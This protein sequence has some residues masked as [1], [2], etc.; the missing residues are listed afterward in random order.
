MPTI[1]T[2]GISINIIAYIFGYIAKDIILKQTPRETEIADRIKDFVSALIGGVEIHDHQCEEMKCNIKKSLETRWDTIKKNYNL[3]DNCLS[4]LKYKLCIEVYDTSSFL[5]EHRWNVSGD[6]GEKKYI[7]SLSFLVSNVLEHHKNELERHSK[8]RKWLNNSYREGIA[9]NI[10]EELV[11]TVQELIKENPDLT[12]LNE[13][14]DFRDENQRQHEDMTEHINHRFD[15]LEERISVS[16]FPP[17][18]SDGTKDS[19]EENIILS[20]ERIERYYQKIS[21]IV[22]S[23]RVAEFS[24]ICGS[25]KIIDTYIQ[26]KSINENEKRRPLWELISGAINDTETDGYV[27]MIVGGPGQGKSLF[28]LMSVYEHYNGK[29]TNYKEDNNNIASSYKRVLWFSLSSTPYTNDLNNKICDLP[30]GNLITQDVVVDLISDGVNRMIESYA[31][32]ER[33]AYRNENSIDDGGPFE[34]D[35]PEDITVVFIDGFDDLLFSSSDVTSSS[36]IERIANRVHGFIATNINDNVHN[37]RVFFTVRKNSVDINKDNRNLYIKID[38]LKCDDRKCWYEKLEERLKHKVSVAEGKGSQK[39]KKYKEE[40][41]SIRSY[42]NTY[43][44]PHNQKVDEEKNDEDGEKPRDLKRSVLKDIL[45]IPFLFRI[46]MYNQIENIDSA[47]DVYTSLCD[48]IIDR[49]NLNDDEK[50]LFINK[51]ADKAFELFKLSYKGTVDQQEEDDLKKYF[52]QKNGILKKFVYISKNGRLDFYHQSF[53][54]YFLARFFFEKLCLIQDETIPNEKE[55]LAKDFFACLAY[56]RFGQSK[57]NMMTMLH[58][59]LKHKSTL[60]WDYLLKEILLKRL[61]VINDRSK[62]Q[63]EG[64]QKHEDTEH[65]DDMKHNY[66]MREYNNIF[67]N[68]ISILCACTQDG[69]QITL[70]EEDINRLSYLFR[71]FDLNE[72]ILKPFVKS[73]SDKRI[74]L[75]RALMKTSLILNGKKCNWNMQGADFSGATFS[76]ISFS[77]GADFRG[78]KFHK[79]KFRN[80]IVFGADTR[81]EDVLFENCSFE[82]VDFGEEGKRTNNFK[83][84]IF[85]N[86]NFQ[87]VHFFNCNLFQSVFE[88]SLEQDNNKDF[89]FRNV[90]FKDVTGLQP[91]SFI[92]CS[93]LNVTFNG[94]I[95]DESFLSVESDD[96]FGENTS[97]LAI[98]IKNEKNKEKYYDFF[99]DVESFLKEKGYCSDKDKNYSVDLDE[100]NRLNEQIKNTGYTINTITH[101]CRRVDLEHEPIKEGEYNL[102]SSQ[103]SVVL[104]ELRIL[105][106]QNGILKICLFYKGP[107][108]VPLFIGRILGSCFDILV[109]QSKPSKNGLCRTYVSAG[110]LG[111]EML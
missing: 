46:I 40:L 59:L 53:K 103:L 8:N 81:L 80:K 43:I 79:T 4:D 23:N 47:G 26:P 48:K 29:K 33:E 44:E 107:I 108:F 104:K 61:S 27:H 3:T 96:S 92:N 14:M 11:H 85:R 64:D 20:H 37:I 65:T 10:A 6:C 38:D 5:K 32:F 1:D 51:H 69:S 55:K 87:D 52:S 30:G 93:P 62:T 89:V 2:S 63:G 31:A 70:G 16:Q 109:F 24:D 72:I 88:Y 83:R 42:W 56:G 54:D 82:R 25:E 73:E 71:L 57:D 18:N 7:K 21:N 50:K 17:D 49:Y 22:T 106:E 105:M 41:E 97:V 13:I 98:N 58:D 100:K 75:Q 66:C 9:K 95:C 34:S 12:T 28:C 102:A 99:G 74:D 101:T 84:T 19:K 78:C 60:N 76:A 91:S 68:A 111:R 110:S 77:G 39:A 90:A 36:S 67:C 15:V 86:C 45:G 94:K 35:N